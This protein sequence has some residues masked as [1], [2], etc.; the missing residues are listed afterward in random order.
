MS[1]KDGRFRLISVPGFSD[2][3]DFR[4]CTYGKCQAIGN[5]LLKIFC[6]VIR[7]E[8]KK[9]SIKFIIK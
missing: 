3:A 4:A 9:R 8:E 5:L 6:R 1:S 7:G 2:S